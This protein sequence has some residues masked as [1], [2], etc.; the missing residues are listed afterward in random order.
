MIFTDDGEKYINGVRSTLNSQI[1]T[2][3]SKN[4]LLTRVI[5]QRKGYRNIPYTS[6]KTVEEVLIFLD[7]HKAIVAKPLNGSGCEDIHII[8]ATS[9]LTDMKIGDYIFEKYIGGPE[10]RYLVVKDKVVAVHRSDYGISVDID[11]ALER[12]SI[13]QDEW[14]VEMCAQSIA[15]AKLIGLGFAAIDYL[16]DEQDEAHFLEINSAPGLKWFHAPSVGPAVDVA[17]LLLEEFIF[18]KI[19]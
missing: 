12:I 16:I 7:E 2:S 10:I 6:A 9:Q 3:L 5:L 17:G 18:D 13:P 4:K 11:R 1:G 14:D 19:A 15:I 8:R